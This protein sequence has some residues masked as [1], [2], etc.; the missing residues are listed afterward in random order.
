MQATKCLYNI[1]NAISTVLDPFKF[2]VQ[3]RKV[4]NIIMQMII[5]MIVIFFSLDKFQVDCSA[6]HGNF[7][8]RSPLAAHRST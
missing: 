8:T 7:Y 6:K 5:L 4:Q 2:H 1:Q 3:F